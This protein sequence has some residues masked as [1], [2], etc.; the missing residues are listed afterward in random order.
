MPSIV[1]VWGQGEKV[2]NVIGDEAE[3]M[4]GIG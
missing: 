3:P 1:G 2:A 4:G